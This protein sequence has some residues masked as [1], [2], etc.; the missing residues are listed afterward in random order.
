[1]S[2][3]EVNYAELARQ[4]REVRLEEE[5]RLRD[6]ATKNHVPLDK[7][8]DGNRKIYN[9][10]KQ[11]TGQELEKSLYSGY[12]WPEERPQLDVI[13]SCM[14]GYK[15]IPYWY[16]TL[17]HYNPGN[18]CMS[19]KRMYEKGVTV[20]HP[21]IAGAMLEGKYHLV[22]LNEA[23]GNVRSEVLHDTFE[24]FMADVVERLAAR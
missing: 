10:F 21:V 7:I 12:S 11:F 8:Y 9:A 14:V 22:E 5:Q 4:K 20:F 24:D 1:M 2:D 15:Q 23:F 3:K 17:G 19:R 13:V 18:D 16:V 6:E